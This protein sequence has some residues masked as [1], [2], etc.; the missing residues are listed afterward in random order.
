LLLAACRLINPPPGPGALDC[1]AVAR[2]LTPRGRLAAMISLHAH[3]FGGPGHVPVVGL[4]H[5]VTIIECDFQKGGGGARSRKRRAVAELAG[6]GRLEG[7]ER[8]LKML[9]ADLDSIRR[10]VRA[11]YP[12][13]YW[14]L[15]RHPTVL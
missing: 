9:G 4:S 6:F 3:A 5:A 12:W 11:R 10:E 8:S 1:Q 7:F 13:T 14:Y 15:L 2:S